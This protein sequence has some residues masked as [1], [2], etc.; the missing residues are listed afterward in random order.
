MN[1]FDTKRK[2]TQAEKEQLLANLDIEVE[3]KVRQFEAW[4]S[5][6]LEN[7]RIYQEGQIS[8]VPKLVRGLT[9][10][11]FGDKYNGDVQA[12][13]R[14]VQRERMGISAD[15]GAGDIEIDKSTRKRKW[16]ASMEAEHQ[17]AEGSKSVKNARMASMSP[18]KKPGSSTG[19]GTAQRARLAAASRTPGASRTVGRV[20]PSPSPVKPLRQGGLIRPP[21]PTKPSTQANGKPLRATRPPS[22]AT[23]NPSLPK[24]P[25]FPKS[26]GNHTA[27]ARAPRRHENML[28]TNGSP[29]AN[30]Y[31]L[32]LEW[33]AEGRDNADVD[34]DSPS[35]DE[36]GAQMTELKKKRSSII[37]RRDPSFAH[38]PR[39]G[40]HSRTASQSSIF[41]TSSQTQPSSQTSSIAALDSEFATPRAA[42]RGPLSRTASATM[43]LVTIP[44][45]D[46]HLLEFDA[47]QTSPGTLDALEGITD[48]AKKQAK[49]DMGRLVRAAVAK[50]KIV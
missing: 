8:R 21:S 24:T 19:P 30:P 34:D 27:T 46:G 2:Y 6:A 48:S 10:R 14:G 32:G 11:E 47:L 7:F 25:G 17:L 40:L 37:V 9:M 1:S 13:L 45:R 16:V 26:E 5:D 15:A 4:L 20:P 28:S 50:W 22:I 3:H 12:A 23:F 35:G 38:P 36:A 43:A 42:P 29:L 49:E 18:Q 39:S 44:T 33:F 31:D 41:S